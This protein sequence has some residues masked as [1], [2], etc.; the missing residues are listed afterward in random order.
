MSKNDKNSHIFSMRLKDVVQLNMKNMGLCLCIYEVI[1]EIEEV[2]RW[3]L[4]IFTNMFFYDW[5]DYLL[6]F[7]SIPDVGT[8]LLSIGEAKKKNNLKISPSILL[9][10][11]NLSFFLT[12]FLS[13]FL[14]FI[15]VKLFH[16][17]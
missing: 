10:W 17:P 11:F 12:F 15:Y 7:A 9:C 6:S 2:H 5:A 13:F 16:S 8:F 3:M 4:Y 14:S 1:L